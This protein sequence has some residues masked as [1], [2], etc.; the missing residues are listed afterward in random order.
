MNDAK[1]I[2][3]GVGAV[4]AD[5]LWGRM[6]KTNRYSYL[7]LAPNS[8][9]LRAWKN[10]C[11]EL[12]PPTNPPGNPGGSGGSGSGT[13]GSGTG[14]GSGSGSGSGDGSGNGS[15]SSGSGSSGSGSSGSGSSGSGSSGGSSG[16]GSSGGSSGSGSSGSG[17]A[18]GSSGDNPGSGDIYI[19][20]GIW[21]SQNPGVFCVP[22]CVPILPPLTL[23][24]PTTISFPLLTTSL[25]VAHR[26]TQVVTVD[27]KTSTST[28]YNRVTQTTVLTIPPVTTSEIEFWNVD[29]TDGSN[30]ALKLTESILPSPFVIT[31]DQAPGDIDR[32]GTRTITPP[33]FPYDSEATPTF[34]NFPSVLSFTA[35]GGDDNSNGPKGGPSCK[36]NCGNKCGH[37][38]GLLGLLVKAIFCNKPCFL[39]CWKPPHP[40]FIDP[41]DPDPP[42]IDL[43]PGFPPPGPPPGPPGG[44]PGGGGNGDNPP[45]DN[46][47]Q[48]T[49]S[50]E[51]STESCTTRTVT[52]FYV[53]CSTISSGSTSCTTTKTSV[54]QGCSV[55]ATTETTATGSFCPLVT[56]DP[57]DDQGEDGSGIPDPTDSGPPNDHSGLSSPDITGVP[58]PPG[59]GLSSPDLTSVPPPPPPAPSPT[60]TPTPSHPP[61]VFYIGWTLQAVLVPA[62]PN[63]K[64]FQWLIYAVE[65]AKAYDPCLPYGTDDSIIYRDP[66]EQGSRAT[67]PVE[68]GGFGSSFADKFDC[69][70]RRESDDEDKKENVPG[71]LTC[72]G[73]LAQCIDDPG[74]TIK[75]KEP[76]FIEWHPQVICSFDVNLPGAVPRPGPPGKH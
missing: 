29:I 72:S 67:Y 40:D 22:P 25:E 74:D 48:S 2:A 57:N 53:S 55:T 16:S 10:G 36:S 14:S 34:S 19:D 52:D 75:C 28:G 73:Q 37:Q 1:P 6:E 43:P 60:P 59:P 13:T 62:F 4:G 45:D 61:T 32:P 31:N 68:L 17:S 49:R 3:A 12:S 18:G 41:N 47:S 7:A 64:E 58:P 27:G 24:Q 42:H 5:V 69:T 26:T 33:S 54:L 21:Q 50:T 70:Y 30:S 66:Y 39:L 46:N 63:E 11:D 71:G 56:L 51:S 38:G 9:T 8:G 20:P 44:N 35:K 15:G 65:Q 23:P 76:P